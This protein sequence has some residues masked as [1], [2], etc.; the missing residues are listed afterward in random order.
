MKRIFSWL[1]A[2]LTVSSCVMFGYVLLSAMKETVFKQFE[3]SMEDIQILEQ[4]GDPTWKTYLLSYFLILFLIID[5]AIMI[6][7]A[8]RNGGS[9]ASVSVLIALPI[10]LFFAFTALEILDANKGEYDK[11][12]FLISMGLYAVS[13]ISMFIFVILSAGK[14][15]TDVPGNT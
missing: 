5:S 14:K 13:H 2:L 11:K 12:L 8:V 3:M 7:S 6:V 10:L 1:S 9:A 15:K 4:L